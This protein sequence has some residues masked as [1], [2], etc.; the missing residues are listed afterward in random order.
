MRAADHPERPRVGGTPATPCWTSPRCRAGESQG[1]TAGSGRSGLTFS[2]SRGLRGNGG[3]TTMLA[4]RRPTA[5]AT[6]RRTRT[7]TSVSELQAPEKWLDRKVLNRPDF[8][9]GEHEVREPCRARGLPD[10]SGVS[11]H[12][13]RRQKQGPA[14]A[15][16]ARRKA[17]GPLCRRIVAAR[18]RSAGVFRRCNSGFSIYNPLLPPTNHDTRLCPIPLPTSA[19]R[20]PHG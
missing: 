4:C 10:A 5:T 19:A 18:S 8:P 20:L 3:T 15:G 14:A 1:R 7:T 9:R 6:I 11:A 12:R 17:A 13:A 2:S 16:V